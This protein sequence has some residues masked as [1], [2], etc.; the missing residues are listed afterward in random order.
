MSPDHYL[1]DIF[2]QIQMEYEKIGPAI[3]LYDISLFIEGCPRLQDMESLLFTTVI[4][5][6]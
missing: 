1:R 2:V 5:D 3:L 6:L 4:P